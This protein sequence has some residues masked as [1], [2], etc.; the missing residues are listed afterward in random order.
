MKHARF[1]RITTAQGIPMVI[2]LVPYGERY[3]RAGKLTHTFGLD[4]FG[5]MVE[6]YDAR[7]AHEDWMGFSGQ[8][9]T[10]YY[11]ETLR[12]RDQS[13]G[14]C[15]NGSVTVWDVDGLAMYYVMGWLEGVMG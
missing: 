9:I 13:R 14:L 2:R 15:L 10:R 12:Q 7:H 11:V 3:G 1:T 5:P 8:F 4:E 6:F